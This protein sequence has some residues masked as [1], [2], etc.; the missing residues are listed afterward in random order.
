MALSTLYEYP[1]DPGKL[2]AWS[3]THAA[4]HR[5]VIRVIF[6]TTG[7]VLDERILDPFDPWDEGNLSSWLN[8]HQDM[9]DQTNAQLG[10][11]G[12][13]IWDV[14]WSNPDEMVPWLALNAIEHLTW[15]EALNLS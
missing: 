10:L 11:D 12:H 13:A 9:H 2:Q 3:F 4:H 15:G 1:T 6:E 8:A 7:V 5:D 14:D